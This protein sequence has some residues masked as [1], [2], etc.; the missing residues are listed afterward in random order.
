MEQDISYTPFLKTATITEPPSQGY[1]WK[2][3]LEFT[4]GPDYDRVKTNSKT[5]GNVTIQGEQRLYLGNYEKQFFSL[6]ITQEIHY[7]SG[8]N[9]LCAILVKKEGTVTPYYVYTDHLGSLITVTDAAGTVVA[10]QNFDAWGR[11]RNPVNWQYTGVPES[12][13]WLY[14]GYTGHEHL[15]DFNLINMNGRMY[16]PVQGRMLSPDN[17]VADAFGT[18]GYNRYSYAKNNPLSYVDPDGNNP[19]V[20]AI[21]IGATIGAFTN[22]VQA[23]Q[24]GKSFLSG[25]WKGAVVGGIGG[26]LGLIGNPG[27]FLGN[28]ALG[29]GEGVFTSSLGNALNGRSLFS[30][31]G[32]AALWGAA[33]AAI[34]SDNTKNL[35]NSHGFRSNDQVL[36]RFVNAENYQEALD[37]FNMDALYTSNPSA[38]DGSIYN[39]SY[40]QSSGEIR[41][42]EYAF[43][44]GQDASFDQLNSV[45][46]KELWQK[47]RH[48]AGTY[49]YDFGDNYNI[50]YE[51]PLAAEDAFGHMFQ[52][53]NV[54]AF[55]KVNRLIPDAAEKGWRNFIS[56]SSNYTR[57]FFKDW[58]FQGINS[59][60]YKIP[61][62]FR[63]IINFVPKTY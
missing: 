58:K 14:R 48:L 39:G 57:H 18:Q 56:Y 34:T 24:Q 21:I 54:G 61:R 27:T 26:A 22:G 59:F 30:G 19:L 16:D 23:D 7:V 37:Y 52:Q 42:T 53:K 46:Q 63:N 47:A 5:T 32:S 10:E 20:V 33:F 38:G 25:A 11:K 3:V 17:Y 35:L 51:N 15:P 55:P 62:R 40:S 49:Y 6:G 41:V 29:A 2:N 60:I 44:L 43:K 13:G 9:G 1:A 45:Y 50:R 36:Q 8:G 12:P 31:A 4:Y 28:V